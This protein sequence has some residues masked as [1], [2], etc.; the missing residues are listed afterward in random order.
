MKAFC[1]M[2]TNSPVW[3]NEYEQGLKE[4]ISFFWS[5]RSDQKRR[6][7]S[8]KVADTGSRSAVTGGRQMNSFADLMLKITVDAGVPRENIYT[9]ANEIPGYFRP[10]KRWDFVVISS[11]N[12]LIACIE[13]KSQVGSFGNNFNNRVEEALGSSVDLHTVY[14]EN[15]F[16]AQ[17]APW[18]GYLMLAER[19]EGSTQ[20]VKVFEP[21]FKVLKE[22]Q[23]TS[24]LDRYR[25]LCDK[26][27]K[28]R[29]YTS[30]SLIW[31][32]AGDGQVSYGYVDEELTFQ[33]FVS[34]YIG[35]L[36]GRTNREFR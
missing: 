12:H 27:I 23:E 30:A 25:I 24:Y 9:D 2:K 35:Y 34:S 18:L 20:K 6:Q 26:L 7:I 10:T 32:E 11:S 21:H 17:E 15:A 33:R 8:K 31:T 19:T 13:F 3:R 22:F 36:L 28:E 5:T 29:H 4:A 16:G 1:T 14:R